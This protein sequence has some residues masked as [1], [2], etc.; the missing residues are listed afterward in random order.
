MSFSGTI[1]QASFKQMKK[2]NGSRTCYYCHG[3]E[4]TQ[5]RASV[6]PIIVGGCDEGGQKVSKGMNVCIL[7]VW[8]KPLKEITLRGP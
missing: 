5:G 2:R 3:V 6:V 8:G 7:D 4:S 1:G